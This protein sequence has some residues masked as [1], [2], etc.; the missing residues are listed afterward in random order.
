MRLIKLDVHLRIQW[1]FLFI[2]CHGNFILVTMALK[3][4]AK[5]FRI[6]QNFDNLLFTHYYFSI[7]FAKCIF[8][9]LTTSTGVKDSKF[10][11]EQAGCASQFALAVVRA[12]VR[13]A[14]RTQHR[15][16][17]WG[18]SAYRTTAFYAAFRP[19]PALD[20]GTRIYTWNGDIKSYY[21]LTQLISFIKL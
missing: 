15:L 12:W 4:P 13:S 14:Y 9:I 19:M 7:H 2:R 21:L 3:L 1:T 17:E 20:L 16:T 18:T 11:P 5:I 8:N 6:P 10:P